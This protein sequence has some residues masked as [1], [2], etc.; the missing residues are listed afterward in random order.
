MGTPWQVLPDVASVVE[1]EE[2]QPALWG[3]IFSSECD[4][5]LVFGFLEKKYTR[6]HI[7][8][9]RASCIFKL[10][11]YALTIFCPIEKVSFVLLYSDSVYC[12]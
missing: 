6:N 1:S 9:K 10:A 7:C 5:F 8:D 4:D 3:F 11:Y 2:W 12:T